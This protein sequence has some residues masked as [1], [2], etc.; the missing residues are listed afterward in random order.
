MDPKSPDLGILVVILIQYTVLS[1]ERKAKLRKEDAANGHHHSAIK[2]DIRP[3][4]N[5]PHH[6]TACEPNPDI[7]LSASNLFII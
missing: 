5:Y 3:D 7:L 4:I 1:K 2:L 6:I